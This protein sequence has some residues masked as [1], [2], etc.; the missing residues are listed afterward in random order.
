MGK[1]DS[2]A[3]LAAVRKYHFWGLCAIAVL[4]SLICWAIA[5]ADLGKQYQ[6]R[7]QKLNGDLK[8]MRDI[9]GEPN[10]PNDKVCAAVQQKRAA[11]QQNVHTTWDQLYAAQQADNPW[12]EVLGKDFLDYIKTLAADAEIEVPYRERYQNFI[13]NDLPSLL[14]EYEIRRDVPKKGPDGKPLPAVAGPEG[15]EKRVPTERIGLVEWDQSDIDRVYKPFKWDAVPSTLRV[16]LA[17]EDLW[18]YRALLSIIRDTNKGATENEYAA[19]KRIVTMEIGQAAA[20]AWQKAKGA[21]KKYMIAAGGEEPGNPAEQPPAETGE[22]PAGPVEDAAAKALKDN[23]Y[24]DYLGKPLP[25][26]APPPFPELKLMPIHLRLVVNQEKLPLLLTH[27]TNSNMPVEVRQLRLNKVEAAETKSEASDTTSGDSAPS[28]HVE[29]TKGAE[30][31]TLNM[32]VEIFGII[33]IY[34]RPPDLPKAEGAEAP[35]EK[36]AAEGSPA[37]GTEAAKQGT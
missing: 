22:Q 32:E 25:A 36:A 23:R 5:T 27:C 21:S 19:V 28:R 15:K 7:S 17:Q 37:A 16:R 24:V 8:A 6:S 4:A 12:P 2:K 10:F 34:N 13:A 29:P 1:T 31:V 18:V 9:Q 14:A 11:L 33:T 26:G 20:A 35:A 3:V 30:F